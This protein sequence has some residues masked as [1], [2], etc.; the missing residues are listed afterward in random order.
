LFASTSGGSNQGQFGN[1]TVFALWPTGGGFSYG[2]LLTL[3]GTNS[4]GP[5]DSLAKDGGG[6]FYATGSDTVFELTQPGFYLN[7]HNFTGRDQG[8]WNGAGVILDSEGYLYGT[9][10]RRHQ[11][12]LPGGMRNGLHDSAVTEKF[13]SG[14]G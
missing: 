9:A 10:R 12:E 13:G 4:N 14:A 8:L 1:G 5:A 7:L 3:P 6:N 2:L 11:P